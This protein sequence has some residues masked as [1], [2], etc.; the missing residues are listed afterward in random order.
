[1]NKLALQHWFRRML[2][3]AMCERSNPFTV[4]LGNRPHYEIQGQ[5]LEV[6]A[7]ANNLYEQNL[8]HPDSDNESEVIERSLTSPSSPVESKSEEGHD[9]NDGNISYNDETNANDAVT[10]QNTIASV[11]TENNDSKD[12][13][14]F[15]SNH[16]QSQESEY[17]NLRRHKM[18]SILRVIMNLRRLKGVSPPLPVWLRANLK[19][20]M[21]YTM[22][23]LR[24]RCNHC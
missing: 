19:K 22:L 3:W 15:D 12:G 21:I 24:Y 10:D 16:R 20:D 9:E 14:T 1:M 13:H 5:K 23:L 4:I 7:Y 17:S 6:A 8:Q 2:K 11:V 18:C